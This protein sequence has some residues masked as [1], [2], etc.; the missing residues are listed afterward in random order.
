MVEVFFSVTIFITFETSY[1]GIWWV[2]LTLSVSMM[3][4]SHIY[5]NST[6]YS[7]FKVTDDFGPGDSA[8][9]MFSSSIWFNLIYSNFGTLRVYLMDGYGGDFYYLSMYPINAST[10]LLLMLFSSD[11]GVI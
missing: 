11:L 2:T 10:G 3:S 9:I 6:S 7:C 1:N 5:D 4:D 8:S